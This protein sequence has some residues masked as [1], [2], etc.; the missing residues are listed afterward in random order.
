MPRIDR[1]R[2]ILRPLASL[3][4]LGACSAADRPADRGNLPTAGG[5]VLIAL[6]GEPKT[7]L[8][9]LMA[10]E[11]EQAIVEV[12]Y[13]RLADIGP[14]LDVTDLE[15][16]TPRLARTWRWS[17]DS[18]SIAFTLDARVRWHDGQP[19]VANDVVRTFALYTDARVPTGSATLLAN[20]DSVTAS[21]STTAVFWF[22]RRAPQ[23]FY[24]AVHHMFIM[25]AHWLTSADPSALGATP[26]ARAPVGTGAFRFQ[27]WSADGRIELIADTANAR[28]RP[29]L[30]RVIYEPVPDAGSAMVKLLAGESDFAAPLLAQVMDQVAT[31]TTIRAVTYPSLRYQL[32]TFNLRAPRGSTAPHRVLGD[33]SVR[34]A[35]T[36]ASNVPRIV[37]TVF[38]SLGEP[39]RGPVPRLA[40]PD[41]T[42]ITPIGYAPA[43]ARALLDSAGWRAD[44]PDGLRR[45]DGVPLRID[46]LVPATSE[47]RV[48]MAV[49]LQDQWRSIGAELVVQRLELNAL[50]A[51]FDAGDYDAVMNGWSL[52]PGLVGLRQAWTTPSIGESNY[53][54][55]A[56][57]SVDANIDSMLLAFDSPTRT[58]TLE[59]AVQT[60]IDDAPAIWLVEDRVPAGMHRRIRPG[61]LSPLGWWHGLAAWQIA[62]DQQLDRDRIGLGTA[63]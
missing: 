59:R 5:T 31:S 51:R 48:R 22:K 2:A 25:P 34:R 60:I 32:L 24:D 43:A 1:V 52:A 16:F 42:A 33:A 13:E 8:P 50:I 46:V 23:Q 54:Y 3:F 15:R 28:G 26:L 29:A 37:R 39:A 20:I 45:R 35:L 10:S 7:L 57:P 63:P 40:L 61:T 62:P 58:R 56:N 47:N 17:A 19:L 38:D 21:D 49:L 9:A 55:Y 14:A 12:L 11:H 27:R 53:A 44:G 6:I 4:V 18:L 41:T 36:M 30:D